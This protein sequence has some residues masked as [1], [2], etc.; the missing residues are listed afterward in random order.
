[1]SYLPSIVAIGGA[2]ESGKDATAEYMATRGYVVMG[3]SDPLHTA[4]LAV[5]PWVPVYYSNHGAHTVRYS[6]LIEQ[7]GYVEAKKNPEVRRL[8]QALGTEVG[9]DMIGAN[10]WVNVARDRITEAVEAGK[11]VVITGIRF[12]NEVQV[13][14]DLGAELVWINRPGHKSDEATTN[15]SSENSVTKEDFDIVVANTG[16]LQE[17]YQRVEEQVLTARRAVR[18]TRD[19]DAVASE[20]FPSYEFLDKEWS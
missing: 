7:L 12:P 13:M 17:L 9:R 2:K 8:L 20:L 16:S 4:L 19:L 10:T 6:T 11:R 18:H 5:D 14:R 1:M 15:H 3:M